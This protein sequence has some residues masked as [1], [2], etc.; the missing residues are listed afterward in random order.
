MSIH[1]RQVVKKMKSKIKQHMN[2]E[3]KQKDPLAVLGYGIV[4]YVDILY[5][6]IWFF[7]AFSILSLPMMLAY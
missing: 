7:I 2:Q 6:S 5:K 4:A 1:G 3:A